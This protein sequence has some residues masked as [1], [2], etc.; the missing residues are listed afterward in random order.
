MKGNKVESYRLISDEES[1]EL[2]G[3]TLYRTVFP[4]F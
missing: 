4:D 1:K 2:D 3:V